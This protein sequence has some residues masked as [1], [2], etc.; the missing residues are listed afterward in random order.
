MLSR[1]GDFLRFVNERRYYESLATE[2]AAL[3]AQLAAVGAELE[4]ER[5]QQ[6]SSVSPR[7]AE[8]IERRSLILV[9]KLVQM[10]DDEEKF[11]IVDAGAREVD[12]DLRWRPFPPDRLS[13][14]GFEPDKEEAARLN[15]DSAAAGLS[16]HFVAAGLWSASGMRD[17]EHNNIGGG[18][19]F[20]PQ[21]RK[22]TDRWK[23]E[24]PNEARSARDI[25]FPVKTERIEV[26]SLAD[27]A[28]SVQIG[29]IDFL[30]LNVQGA[31]K[32]ILIGAGALLDDILG[33]L[34]EV[35]FVETYCGRPMFA[36]IDVMLREHGFSFFDL[37]AHHYIGRSE[38]PIAAQ[39]LTV[40]EPKLG[41]LV[42]TWGQLVEGH[43]LYLRDPIAGNDNLGFA[44]IV[45]LAALAEAF[46]QIEF[47]FELIGWLSARANL[48]DSIM[49]RSLQR[50]I[51]D[52]ILE[53]QA[54]LRP[55]L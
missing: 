54:L 18:S 9:R 14:V 43:A 36:D 53:Y 15:A 2:N 32:E 25:F 8:Y 16:R 21:N 6:R 40:G 30:K 7:Q 22:V 26:I 20:I 19:S 24:N 17:F 42:S 12:R 37:L 38:S 41:Q 23:F 13:F 47:A 39:H 51:K 1:I 49:A 11:L 28:A 3:K 5:R 45:K 35:S 33:I 27:W 46:G 44:R 31:E 50:F 55:G 34:V 4:Q 48:A 29:K 10:L 52:A